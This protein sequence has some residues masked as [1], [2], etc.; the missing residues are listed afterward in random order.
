MLNL[1]NQKV[2]PS[3]YHQKSNNNCLKS[4]STNT[5]H[6]DELLQQQKNQMPV[7]EPL[8]E[9]KYIPNNQY[10]DLS[11]HI[12]SIDVKVEDTSYQPINNENQILLVA[13]SIRSYL[14]TPEEKS[15]EPS[16]RENCH[17]EKVK[18]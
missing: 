15:M 13:K 8:P 17:I 10:T 11:D 9:Y 2:I 18:I 6:I 16:F 3:V 12:R 4:I 5:K 14:S 7:P 1:I